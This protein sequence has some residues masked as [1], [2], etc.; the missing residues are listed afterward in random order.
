MSI[1]SPPKLTELLSYAYVGCCGI[2]QIMQKYGYT[3]DYRVFHIVFDD[4]TL[5]GWCGGFPGKMELYEH[6]IIESADRRL[7]KVKAK[8][9]VLAVVLLIHK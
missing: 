9:S 8:S 5:C 3:A 2:L 7:I 6:V 1:A 4:I